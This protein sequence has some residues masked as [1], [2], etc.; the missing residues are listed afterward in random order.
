MISNLTARHFDKEIK[1]NKQFNNASAS[2]TNN[3]NSK[4]N[5][6]C[7]VILTTHRNRLF[8]QMVQRFDS[9]ITMW[10]N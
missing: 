3:S 7:K 9:L 4:S 2:Q 1:R 5:K 6:I 10:K 8:F